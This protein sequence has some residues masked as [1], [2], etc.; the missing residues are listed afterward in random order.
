[1]KNDIYLIPLG[2]ANGI[3]ASCYFLKLGKS[4]IV[5]D[6]GVGYNKDLVYGP[7]LYLLLKSLFVNSLNEIDKIFISHGHM[8]HIGFLLNMM[9]E[10][11]KASV[12]MT[13]I[14]RVFAEYQL[15]DKNYIIG[16]SFSTYE[17]LGIKIGLDRISTL[18]YMKPIDFGEYKVT[19]FQAG[20]IPGACMMLFEYGK[21]KIL[22]T[23]DYSISDT[24]MT[25]KCYI[26][27]DIE[28]DTLIIC[29]VH[30]KH[31]N[32]SKDE[33]VLLDK[34]YSVF[35]YINNG[36]SVCCTIPQLSKGIEFLKILND[37][38]YKNIPIYIDNSVINVIEKLEKLSIPIF[39]KN[40]FIF[41]QKNIKKPHILLTSD[42]KQ[43][44]NM[45]YKNIRIDFSIHDDFNQIKNFITNINPKYAYVVHYEKE[46]SEEDITIEQE[47]LFNSSC[48]TQVIFTE[49]GM[50]Y[51]L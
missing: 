12:Y 17:E 9:K 41:N 42:K 45:F 43:S 24:P 10:A 35:N 39:E 37:M 36:H 46:K 3:G 19:F 29:S 49:E 7:N 8:D 14:T 1:M 4:N 21:R 48:N 13:D 16:N 26:P 2:G 32:Y 27:D 47:I 25:R 34:V 15:Y 5:L 38:N 28:I 23:G 31:S 40:N 11:S 22:Y 30:S 50:I 20:H 18:S 51:N 33:N 44:N 6:A